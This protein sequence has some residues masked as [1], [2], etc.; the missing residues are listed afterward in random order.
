MTSCQPPFSLHLDR[1]PDGAK[2][3][4][5]WRFS[6]SFAG[7]LF[8]G[9]GS[10]KACNPVGLEA[11]KLAGWTGLEPATFCVTEEVT[12]LISGYL[13]KSVG[14]VWGNDYSSSCICDLVRLSKPCFL[15]KDASSVSS[16]TWLLS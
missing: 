16:V 5:F 1:L 14:D 4:C 7:G 6:A 10:K 8:P 2:I 11:F 15:A 13:R 3:G 12:T 9:I